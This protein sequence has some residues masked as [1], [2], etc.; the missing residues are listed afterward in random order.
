MPERYKIINEK[1]YKNFI[2]CGQPIRI[3][4]TRVLYDNEIKKVILQF[5]LTNVSEEIIDNATIKI[6]GY[7]CSD[8]EL[9]EIEKVLSNLNVSPNDCFGEKTPLILS[10]SRISKITMIIKRVVMKSGKKWDN[11]DELTGTEIAEAKEINFKSELRNELKR[12]AKEHQFN[13]KCMFEKT[14]KHWRCSCGALNEIQK[15]KCYFC[16]TNR[17]ILEQCFSEE[18]L[19]RKSEEYCIEEKKK[20][21]KK[22]QELLLSNDVSEVKSAKN[23]FMRLDDWEDSKEFIKQCNSKVKE[24]N[25]REER[26]QQSKKKKRKKRIAGICITLLIIFVGTITLVKFPII[27]AKKYYQKKDYE[28]AISQLNNCIIKTRESTRL[29]NEYI[30]KY[31][32]NLL[33]KKEYNAVDSLVDKYKIDDV[34]T[35]LYEE[36]IRLYEKGEYENAYECL[37]TITI[38]L[39]DSSKKVIKESDEDILDLVN[40]AT[41]SDSW[42]ESMMQREFNKGNYDKALT[43]AKATENSKYEFLCKVFVENWSLEKFILHFPLNIIDENELLKV[44]YRYREKGQIELGISNHIMTSVNFFNMSETFISFDSNSSESLDGDNVISSIKIDDNYGKGSFKEK[45]GNILWKNIKKEFSLKS[46]EIKKTTKFHSYIVGTQ[47]ITNKEKIY[48]WKKGKTKYSFIRYY[49]NESGIWENEGNDIR[50]DTKYHYSV[51]D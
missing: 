29:K 42:I 11:E 33:E 6:I 24:L 22:A 51:L 20:S 19:K 49:T 9:M 26:E 10:D 23:I 44:Q 43:I 39:G 18:N 17:T 25:E 12:E 40:D 37:I 15:K 8:T 35:L 14:D 30:K 16:G 34:Y 47:K 13:T 27:T 21:Y 48:M 3:E 38:D 5:K 41:S 32:E 46:K 45:E 1:D 28:K 50:I 36:G 31:A 4:K 2:F 7:D